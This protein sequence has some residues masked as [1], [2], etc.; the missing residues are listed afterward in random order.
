M[1]AVANPAD[2]DLS[3][4][5]TRRE[6]EARLV[7]AQE[8]ILHLRLVLGGHLGDG[9]HGPPVCVVLEGWDA[10]GK[11]GAI[12]R[13]VAPLDS[14]HIRVSGFSKPTPDE[15]RHHFL[16]R[17]WPA[18]PGWGGMAVFDRSWYG[19][20]LVERV[21][22]FATDAQWQRAY[23]EISEFERTLADDGMI[24]VKLWMHISHEEQR[25]R[26]ERRAQDPLKQWKLGPEDWRNREK[27]A[28]YE[29]ALVDMLE[30][31]E[32][33]LAP[34]DVI[35]AEDK[36][37]ARVKVI[38]TVIARIEA[39]MRRAGI[40]PPDSLPGTPGQDEAPSVSDVSAR[41]VRP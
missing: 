24:I 9:R 26:F 34:W 23:Q 21:E 27:R 13:L 29:A 37:W 6:E 5:M 20:V 32:Q 10:A 11:G 36:R 30:R 4:R 38:E 31:T 25:R 18:L 41:A 28:P 40:E 7:L 39:G 3:L 16:W 22:G 17:F 15:K 2:V 33:P 35:E 14:R 8:R 1:G 19:R 12:R